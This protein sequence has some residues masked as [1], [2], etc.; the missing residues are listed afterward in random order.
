VRCAGPVDANAGPAP[1]RPHRSSRAAAARR[2][3]RHVWTGLILAAAALPAAAEQAWVKPRA[4]DSLLIS[5]ARHDSRW[6]VAGERGHVLISDDARS[7]RQVPVP[8]RVMLT[9]VDLA[10]D[11]LGFAVGHEATI[12]R[13]RDNGETWE[14]V[15]HDPAEQAPFLDVA[16]IDRQR[17]VAVGAYGLYAESRDAGE[18]WDLMVIEPE[19]LDPATAGQED[20]FFYDYHLNEL[21]VAD[22]GR[23]YIAAEAGT[24]Y[25]SDDAG[26][27]W[28]R[29]PS[30]YEGSFFGVLPM[31]RNEVLLFGLQGRLFR[32]TDAGE[33]WQRIDTGTDATLTSGVRSD[34][35]AALIAGHAGIVLQRRGDGIHRTRLENRPGVSD[36]RL[37]EDGSVLTAGEGGIRRWPPD[38]LAG[39]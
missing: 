23:W 4:G 10:G 5:I 6:L 37:L 27:T 29:L 14:R 39:R 22:D 38:I 1:S 19:E 15:Y 3:A 35:G 32:S 11:G 34:D 26:G 7:W 31:R 36:V 33:S 13:T 21:A 18:T 20:E 30:P 8:T 2:A 16:V 9:G 28:K 25:R 12:V 17:V 24:V